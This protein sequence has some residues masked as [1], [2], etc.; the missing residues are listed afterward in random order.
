M[1]EK[2][3]P[4]AKPERRQKSSKI[5]LPRALALS[6]L[7]H[8]FGG[9]L[10]NESGKHELSPASPMALRAEAEK[11]QEIEQHNTAFEEK[12]T[13][14]LEAIIDDAIK[15]YIEHQ[16]TDQLYP[17]IDQ[18]AMVDGYHHALTYTQTE[19]RQALTQEQFH[20][21]T[22]AQMTEIL[23]RY[24]SGLKKL[25]A[26]NE[27]TWTGDVRL[28]FPTLQRALFVGQDRFFY[29]PFTNNTSYYL[30]S[31]TVSDQLITGLVNCQVANFIPMLLE[32]IYRAK[33]LP[34]A[35]LENLRALF[36]QDHVQ[37][38]WHN[39]SSTGEEDNNYQLR[40]LN[41]EQPAILG[42]ASPFTNQAGELLPAKALLADYL[43]KHGATA[44]QT[45]RLRSLGL[46]HATTNMYKDDPPP[47]KVESF[48]EFEK[49]KPE[50]SPTIDQSPKGDAK[51][52]IKQYALGKVSNWLYIE[53]KSTDIVGQDAASGIYFL[54]P[55]PDWLKNDFFVNYVARHW[56]EIFSEAGYSLN[57]V[58]RYRIA[59][60]FHLY[61]KKE[62]IEL[63]VKQ[64]TEQFFNNPIAMLPTLN[65]QNTVDRK[66]M[67]RLAASS[68]FFAKWEKLYNAIQQQPAA[69]QLDLL[70]DYQQVSRYLVESAGFSSM[71]AL[72]NEAIAQ[73]IAASNR[74]DDPVLHTKQ[75]LQQCPE[76]K[77]RAMLEYDDPDRHAAIRYDPDSELKESI[78]FDRLENDPEF[79]LAYFQR[80][81]KME[82]LSWYDYD[83]MIRQVK[84]YPNLNRQ[85]LD[86]ILSS[87]NAID[88]IEFTNII[89]DF[90]LA[91]DII[92][93]KVHQEY[94]TKRGTDETDFESPFIFLVLHYDHYA[95]ITQEPLPNK[96]TWVMY[97]PEGFEKHYLN[98]IWLESIHRNPALHNLVIDLY[99]NT[100]SV[101]KR[102]HLLWETSRANLPVIPKELLYPEDL[103]WIQTL[104]DN[105]GPTFE[106]SLFATNLRWLYLP[107]DQRKT[108]AELLQQDKLY[109]FQVD[110]QLGLSRDFAH[111]MKLLQEIDELK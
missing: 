108:T 77:L 30:D 105:A 7:L 84:L 86:L 55:E 34:L 103:L 78:I 21:Q 97:E 5:T 48:A 14:L 61:G 38:V 18:Y 22:V 110:H 98:T 54:G 80:Q 20:D 91:R 85:Y 109:E 33:K 12:Q 60:L 25:L 111:G 51:E 8:G 17:P 27:F 64:Q 44:E 102:Q 95:E 3:P 19:Q 43:V 66:M 87:G 88:L 99:R 89:R 16:S 52:I 59:Q 24:K 13:R 9:R 65:L 96:L 94:Q 62:A 70:F 36:W 49:P 106:G 10:I 58:S 1:P 2:S 57:M 50:I 42:L 69:N 41:L 90:P 37:M 71:I 46:I 93:E 83:V 6:L 29:N 45:E 100:S 23:A 63:M 15:K 76:I 39:P 32:D 74:A 53:T 26:N 47:N 28:D 72:H 31:S 81:A 82:E 67:E 73:L 11:Q 79:I 75:E 40:T 35:D 68:D 56:Q 101:I 107:E 4:A 104:P 92:L